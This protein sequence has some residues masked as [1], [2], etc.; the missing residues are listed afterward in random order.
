MK[1]RQYILKLGILLSTA[2]AMVRMFH[3]TIGF[4]Y[5]TQLSNLFAAGVVAGQLIVGRGGRWS[6]RLKPVKYA[7]TMSIFV[8]FLVYLAVLAPLMP[9]GILAAYRQDHWASLCLHLIT[10]ALTV[11]D[12][13]RNDADYPWR[14]RHVL[15]GIAPPV[16]YVI[17]ILA[18]GRGGVRWGNGSF[19]MMAPYPFLNYAAPAGWFGFMPETAGFST[20]GV[21]V[22]YAVV[23]LVLLFLLTGRLLLAAANYMKHRRNV[24]AVR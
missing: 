24:E 20:L 9:G 13:L 11:A 4:T 5:F 22:F 16:L 6:E 19:A 17:F 12:F 1:P 3:W 2:Y 15:W 10:P 7:A 18:L 21:G 23:A 8:T 14:G